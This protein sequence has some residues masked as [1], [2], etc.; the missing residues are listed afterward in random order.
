MVLL[1]DKIHK[2]NKFCNLIGYDL[3]Q[4]LKLYEGQIMPETDLEKSS[5]FKNLIDSNLNSAQYSYVNKV[6]NLRNKDSRSSEEYARDLVI[7]WLVE[8]MVKD[9]LQ[10]QSNG[11][12]QERVFLTRHKIKYD[13]D[14]KAGNRLLELYVNFTN[15]WTK[16]KKIDLRMDK[17]LHLVE[18]KSLMLG[19]AFEDL[20]FYIIDFGKNEIPFYENYNYFWKKK[21]YTCNKFDDFHDINLMREHLN[22]HVQQY[23]I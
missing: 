8:D 13:S 7:S 10:L 14:F 4:F 1:V 3:N 19:I 11:A 2:F 16:T 5:L 9:Y 17:Y 22:N 15:Y 6:C 21:C 20:K 23:E 18:K 12:D